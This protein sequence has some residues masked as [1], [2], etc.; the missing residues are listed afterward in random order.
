MVVALGVVVGD[1]FSDGR[2]EVALAQE[3]EFAEALAFGEAM[4]L[5]I[6]EAKIA[7][8]KAWVRRKSCS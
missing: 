7:P 8:G 2:A 5:L 6:G 4:P 3:H 1:V